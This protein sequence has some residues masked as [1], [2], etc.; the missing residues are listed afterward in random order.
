[1]AESLLLVMTNAVDGQDDAFNE[2]YESTHI[3]ELLTVP[4]VVSAERFTVAP[5]DGPE[6]AQRYLTVY[7]L[8]GDPAEVLAEFGR[9]AVSGE[10]T[11]SDTLDLTT[12]AMSAWRPTQPADR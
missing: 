10:L 2:W 7:R 9:R 12:V 8:D 1:M 4:G 5:L 3:P 6:P 11:M